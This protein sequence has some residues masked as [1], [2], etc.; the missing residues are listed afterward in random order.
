MASDNVFEL[1]SENFDAHLKEVSVPLLVDF[2]AAWCGPCKAI[3]PILDEL[4][5]EMND[6]VQIA[7]VNV[8]DNSELAAQYNVRSIPTMLVFKD[9]VVVEEMVG[10]SNKMDLK[11]KLEAHL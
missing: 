9:G 10:L 11:E 3:A 2:W 4:A 6:K 7:K 8:D 1:N 5:D